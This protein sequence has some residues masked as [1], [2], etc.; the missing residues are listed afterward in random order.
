MFSIKKTLDEF[1]SN[2]DEHNRIQNA[3]RFCR[4]VREKIYPMLKFKRSHNTVYGDNVFLDMLVHC[5]ITHDF[6]EDGSKTFKLFNK[7]APHV[8]TVLY[9][10]KKFDLDEVMATFEKVFEKTCQMAKSLGVFNKS[11]DIAIDAT[12]QM[13]YGD[14]N[15]P[16]VVKT[17]FKTG[18]NT[19]F[20]FATVNVVERGMRFTLMA[21]PM[22]Q[23]TSNKEVLERLITYAQKKVKIRYVYVDRAFFSGS[24]M[25]MLEKLGVKYI[26][27]A[28]QHRRIKQLTERSEP[29]TV[30]D[31]K[32][33]YRDSFTRKHV[34]YKLVIMRSNQNPET[35]IAF[36]TNIYDITTRNAE[37]VCNNYSK[38][39]GI[40]TS[41]RVKND[42]RVRTTSKNY[43]VRLFYFLLSVCLYN[44]WILANLIVGVLSHF[45]IV[46]KPI[47]SAKI[48][49]TL[50]HRSEMYYGCLLDGLD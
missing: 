49:G 20:R 4:L 30:M 2:K 34:R 16:M 17:K 50:L 27:P 41:Y 23:F 6:T 40:E 19:A 35:K 9:H 10:I 24:C 31:Y 43:I 47:I 37:A 44:F 33:K 14:K 26:M 18:T 42:F 1:G 28:I 12:E 22:S 36:A 39:W 32:M 7:E 46:L 45:N 11:V 25:M 8:N 5:A 29:V 48:F 3:K 15:D 38:R 13:Y 21:I